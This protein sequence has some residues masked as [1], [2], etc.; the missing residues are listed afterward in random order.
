MHVL[1]A[2]FPGFQLSGVKGITI[3]EVTTRDFK[4]T[5]GDHPDSIQLIGSTWDVSILHNTLLATTQGIFADGNGVHTNMQIV[6]NRI[7]VAYANAL[8]ITNGTGIASGNTITKG[9]WGYAP[10]IKL[11]SIRSDG[12]NR[13]DGRAF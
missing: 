6:G 12:T 2:P 5:G 11:S 3:S 9:I 10:I 13:V 8:R 7:G 1:V 4:P